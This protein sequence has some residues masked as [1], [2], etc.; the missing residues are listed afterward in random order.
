MFG[1]PKNILVYILHYL[2]IQMMFIRC[3]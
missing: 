2:V 3:K 1:N